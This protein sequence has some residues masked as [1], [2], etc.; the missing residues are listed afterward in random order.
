MLPAADDTETSVRYNPYQQQSFQDQYTQQQ[1][2]HHYRYEKY[3]YEYYGDMND[4][5]W[6]DRDERDQFI[7]K[8]GLPLPQHQQKHVSFKRDRRKSSRKKSTKMKGHDDIEGG[9]YGLKKDIE[10]SESDSDSSVDSSIS[11]DDSDVRIVSSA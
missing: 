3:K 11:S 7:E 9:E 10:Q 2:E 4:D 1:L 5:Y 8:Y 6:H